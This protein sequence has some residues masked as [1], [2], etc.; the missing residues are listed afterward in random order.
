MKWHKVLT[1]D[2]LKPGAG[3]TVNVFGR[4][5]ALF[6][7][8]E[9]DFKAIDNTCPHKGAPLGEGTLKDHCVVCPLHQWTFNLDTGENIRNPQIKLHVYETKIEG[10]D[11]LVSC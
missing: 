7:I 10:E 11:V 5:I 8:S 9:S 1:V 3:K 2:N 6:R 4:D